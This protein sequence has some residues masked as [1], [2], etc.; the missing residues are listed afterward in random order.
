MFSSSGQV[1]WNEYLVIGGLLSAHLPAKRM[2][3]PVNSSWSCQGPL[4]D[5]AVGFAK[6]VLPRSIN[7]L[8][9]FFLQRSF[10]FSFRY[11]DR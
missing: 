9:S 11:R 7:Y 2:N 1:L 5:L 6:K 4:L 8:S 3:I 10:C